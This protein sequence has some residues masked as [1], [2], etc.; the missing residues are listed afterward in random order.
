MKNAYATSIVLAIAALTAGQVMAAD[1]AMKVTFGADM[2]NTDTGLTFA[3]MFPGRYDVNPVQSKTRAEVRAELV[4]A[5]RVSN[6]GDMVDTQTGL[7]FR[8]MF[9]G[10]Y[11]AS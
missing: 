10:R 5:R 1:N 9:P 11:D 3:Q 2:L 6:G 4:A 8:Q 7:T